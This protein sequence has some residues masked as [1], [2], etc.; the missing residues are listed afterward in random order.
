MSVRVYVEGG[1]GGDH[2]KSLQTE[3]RRGFSEFI[4]KA[5]FALRM[6]RVVACGA[7]RQAYESFRTA[8]EQHG[9]SAP[10]L[11]VDSEGPVTTADPW[12]HVLRR[13]GDQWVR[14]PGASSDQLH[15]MVQSSCRHIPERAQ[16]AKPMI[17]VAK[18][19]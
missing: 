8:Q 7:R 17:S 19:A 18:I 16:P 10:V 4:R 2:N 6:P 11:L 14:P 5:G 1:G 15:F 3:C 9:D 12:E 13:T